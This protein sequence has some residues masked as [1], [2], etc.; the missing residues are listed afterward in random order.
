[1]DGC[2]LRRKMRGPG[3]TGVHPSYLRGGGEKMSDGGG[4]RGAPLTQQACS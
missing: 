4:A 2:S 1:M 3:G